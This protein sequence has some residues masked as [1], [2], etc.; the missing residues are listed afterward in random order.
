MTRAACKR[1]QEEE[2]IDP[3]DEV[4][5]AEPAPQP[6]KP[7]VTHHLQPGMS[8]S[9][10]CFVACV[11]VSSLVLLWFLAR[12]IHSPVHCSR[13][14]RSDLF[15]SAVKEYV[16]AMETDQPEE[17]ADENMEDEE[18]EDDEDDEDEEQEEDDIIYDEDDD[19]DDSSDEDEEEDEE[20]VFEQEKPR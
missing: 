10:M 11:S 20:E 7:R 6:A 8:R 17:Y 19:D 16:P 12:C 1:M 2:N 15:C 9:R 4:M 3:S 13:C 5:V 18:D 14:L